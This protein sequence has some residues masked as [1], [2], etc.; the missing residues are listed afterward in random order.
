MSIKH[1]FQTRVFKKYFAQWQ[2]IPEITMFRRDEVA[3]FSKKFHFCISMER[4]SFPLGIL[5]AIRKFNFENK[6]IV[7][8]DVARKYKFQA[9]GP[10]NYISTKRTFRSSKND[11]KLRTIQ[12]TLDFVK[13]SAADTENFNTKSNCL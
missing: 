11:A 5:F 1:Q 7:R 9:K 6:K 12:C 8:E 10:S 2:N 13:S 3:K 4:P